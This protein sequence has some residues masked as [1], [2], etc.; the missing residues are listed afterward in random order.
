MA[1]I[2][3][4]S[5]AHMHA[6]SY[7]ACLNELPEAELTAIWDDDPGRGKAQA[8]AFDTTFV[9]D[10][11]DFLAEWDARSGDPSAVFFSSP[12]LEVIGRRPDVRSGV[13]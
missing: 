2:G 4:M 5:F 8:R 1:K 9:G 13:R 3:M 7:A 11:D 12:V 10:L 6:L